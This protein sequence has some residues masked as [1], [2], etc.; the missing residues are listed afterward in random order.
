MSVD[1]II[2]ELSK[3]PNL[4][5]V[6][7]PNDPEHHACYVIIGGH[8]GYAIDKFPDNARSYEKRLLAMME[9]FEK[10][11]L[12]EDDKCF[13]VEHYARIVKNCNYSI[14][15]RDTKD[16]QYKFL[17]TLDSEQL[18]EIAKQISMYK[19]ARSLYKEYH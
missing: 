15:G 14:K 17:Q 13:L 7:T 9:I 10:S 3:L 16:A 19:L 18:D 11:E 4:L 2:S 1:E 5:Y 12:T 6:Y 8:K